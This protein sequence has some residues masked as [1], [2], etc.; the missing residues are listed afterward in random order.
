MTRSHVN[1]KECYEQ[2]FKKLCKLKGLNPDKDWKKVQKFKLKD[3]AK[4]YCLA[5]YPK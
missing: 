5:F 1:S 2:T 3:Q 4:Q